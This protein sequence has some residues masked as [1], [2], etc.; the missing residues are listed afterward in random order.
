[1]SDR[2]AHLLQLALKNERQAEVLCAEGNTPMPSRSG[3][4]RLSRRM[5][6]DVQRNPSVLAA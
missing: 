6:K 5:T 3:S 4:S 1:M 2:R